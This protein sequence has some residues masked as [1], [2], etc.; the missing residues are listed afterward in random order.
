MNKLTTAA[1]AALTA[2]SFATPVF[3]DVN[4]SAITISNTNSGTIVSSTKAS[5]ST[6]GNL[7]GGSYAGRGGRGGD[8]EAEGGAA[9]ANGEAMAGNGGNGGN[10][11]AGGYVSTGAA[12][13]DAAS[14]NAANS[15]EVSVK[16]WGGLNS[17]ALTVAGVNVGAIDSRTRAKARTGGNEAEGSYAGNGGKGGEVEAEDGANNANGGAWGGNGG[18]GGDSDIGGTVYTGEAVSTSGSI[19]VLN[20]NLVRVRN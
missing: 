17:S 16:S 18:V 20:T 3:A 6:G 14:A 9:F 2:L 5:A 10:S 7:A 15:N 8:V 13:A 19:N 11:A 1:T 12:S 4:S